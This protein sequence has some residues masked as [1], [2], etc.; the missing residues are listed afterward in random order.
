MNVNRGEIGSND[1]KKGDVDNVIINMHIGINCTFCILGLY[2]F[3]IIFLSNKC[4]I[5]CT[6]IQTLVCFKRSNGKVCF[7]FV[8]LIREKYRKFGGCSEK[9]IFTSKGP[10]GRSVN[11]YLDNL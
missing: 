8:T 10:C 11:I 6:C 3:K 9:S 2:Y 5:K 4:K 1:S 7:D